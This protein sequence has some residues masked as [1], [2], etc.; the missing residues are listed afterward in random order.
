MASELGIKQYETDPWEWTLRDRDG[1][2]NL[3]SSTVTSIQVFVWNHGS[4]SNLVNGSTIAAGSTVGAVSY[5][6][7]TAVVDGTGRFRHLTKVTR[8]TG[9][10]EFYPSD[11]YNTVEIEA[12]RST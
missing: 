6:P 11:G 10:T 8:T 2:V 5:T 1:T 3:S 7:T 12:S 9:R 4:T